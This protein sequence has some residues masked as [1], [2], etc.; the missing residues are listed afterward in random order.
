MTLSRVLVLP[1]DLDAVEVDRLAARDLVDDVDHL[2]VGM[3]RS[4]A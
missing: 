3:S 4:P 2:F 1:V